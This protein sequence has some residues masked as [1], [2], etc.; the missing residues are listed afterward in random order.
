MISPLPVP[1]ALGRSGFERA[2]TLVEVV[3]ASGILAVG[4]AGIL[5][6]CS[7]GLRTAR[8][9]DRVHVDAGS[10]AAMLS[11]TN[12]L[13]E[14]AE[15]GSFGEENPGYGWSSSAVE[16]GTNG[17]FTID[18]TVFSGRNNSGSESRLSILLFRPNSTRPVGR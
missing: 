18:F 13:E 17:L 1:H 10:L 2:F 4:L 12:K 8:V 11:L 9:L 5:L 3:V 6:I 7:N 15:S 14:G 16:T